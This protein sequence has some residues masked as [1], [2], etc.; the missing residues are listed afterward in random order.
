MQRFDDDLRFCERCVRK[1]SGVSAQS[2]VQNFKERCFTRTVETK[3]NIDV[4]VQFVTKAFFFRLGLQ[5]R[6]QLHGTYGYIFDVT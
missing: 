3:E 6:I 4:A 5:R 1:R 2:G